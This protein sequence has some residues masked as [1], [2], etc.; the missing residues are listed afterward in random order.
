MKCVIQH[1]SKTYCKANKNFDELIVENIKYSKH[2]SFKFRGNTKN[3][4]LNWNLIK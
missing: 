3:T 2:L 4:V 1:A